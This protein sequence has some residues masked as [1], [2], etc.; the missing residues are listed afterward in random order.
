MSELSLSVC[1]GV[2]YNEVYPLGHEPEEDFPRSPK[3][4]SSTHSP[5]DEKEDEDED[6]DDEENDNGDEHE[7]GVEED[8][9][10]QSEGGEA[11]DQVDG[12]TWP[13][14]LPLMWTV[15]DFYPK[16]PGKVFNTL[17]DLYQILESIPLRLT[18][19]FEK[20]YSGR[21]VDINMYD[22]MFAARLRLPLTDLYLQLVNYLRFSIN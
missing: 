4:E 19:K 10:D 12:D 15:N 13:F 14:I 9:G 22:A 21:T 5:N 11:V 17:R 6:E 2:G 16:M 1:E 20:R 18:R 8:E 7:E 3:R